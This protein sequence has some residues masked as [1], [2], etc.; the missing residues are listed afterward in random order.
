MTPEHIPFKQQLTDYEQQLSQIAESQ[1]NAT[2]IAFI[3]NTVLAHCLLLGGKN[4]EVISTCSKYSEIA[5]NSGSYSLKYSNVVAI[6]YR[7]IL[8]MAYE[9]VGNFDD[10]LQIYESAAL[11][12]NDSIAASPEALLWAE[13]L[14]YRFS[15]LA[16]SYKWNDSRVTLA[17]LRGYQRIS[18]LLAST[19]VVKN[20]YSHANGLER[21]VYILNAH[22]AYSSALIQNSQN[23]EIDPVTKQEVKNMSERFEKMLFESAEA[24]KSSDSNTP[25]EQYVETMM[26]NWYKTMTFSKHLDRVYKP[27]DIAES[28]KILNLLRRATIKTFHSCVITRNLVFVLAALGQYDEALMAF[29]VYTD[30]QDKARIQLQ[31]LEE[32]KKAMHGSTD[33]AKSVP[34]MNGDDEKSVVRVFAKAIEILDQ[35]KRDGSKAKATADTLRGWLGNY[36]T[37]ASGP[38]GDTARTHTK[39]KSIAS[40]ASADTASGLATVWASIARAYCLFGFQ[41][42]TGEERDHAFRLAGESFESCLSYSPTDAQVYADYGLFLSRTGKVSKALE[43]VKKGLQVD[44][45]NYACWHLMT[46]ALVSIGEPE[47]ALKAITNIISQIS[48]RQNELTMEERKCFLQMKITQIATVEVINGTEKALELIP[49]VFSLF[50]ELFSEPRES[51][52]KSNKPLTNTSTSPQR[53]LATK[54]QTA[55]RTYIKPTMSRLSLRRLAPGSHFHKHHLRHESLDAAHKVTSTVQ[56]V[57]SLG[58]SPPIDSKPTTTAKPPQVS[59]RDNTV[60]QN[61]VLG[62]L[63]LWA[64]SLYRQA[65]LHQESEESIRESESLMGPTVSSHVELGLLIN[66]KYPLQALYE[67]ETALDLNPDSLEA[68][69]AIGQLILTHVENNEKLK[70]KEKLRREKTELEAQREKQL[71]FSENGL[72]STEPFGKEISGPDDLREPKNYVARQA[73]EKT[74]RYYE[75]DDEDEDGHED[76]VSDENFN[77]SRATSFGDSR[78]DRAKPQADSISEEEQSV[79]TDMALTTRGKASDALFISKSDER[80]AIARVMQLLQTV[81]DTGAGFNSSEAWFVLGQL[82]EQIG[83]TE[84]AT[85]A[86]WKSVGYE[87]ARSMRKWTVSRWDL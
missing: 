8:G 63:W 83:D 80:A 44:S 87:E 79:N 5:N 72:L 74:I 50:G 64:A 42:H 41:A 30:Y 10:A 59:K 60:T 14:Y 78:F 71:D 75:S 81:V 16:I 61:E 43:M 46:L 45:R 15:T 47:K 11:I 1:A 31:K 32:S 6:K 7:A 12:I 38:N 82:L 36:D 2:E 34:L 40:I 23:E 56:P 18:D 19:P 21:R 20:Y 54:S 26:A 51:V 68:I 25:I 55:D 52:D 28:K 39:N 77:L 76:T 27:E 67:Y 35:V 22:F 48:Q 29:T 57:Q 85:Q 37:T 3:T 73:S 13:Q 33:A 62:K 4:Q 86:L 65:G 66:Q 69:V 84:A 58:P 53:S 70:E 9:A 24:S 49:E 17:A